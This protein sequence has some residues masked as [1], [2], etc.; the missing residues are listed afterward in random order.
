MSH[1]LNTIK[2]GL[3]QKRVRNLLIGLYVLV[4]IGL[5][6][7]ARAEDMRIFPQPPKAT[8]STQNLQVFE[9][10]IVAAVDGRTFLVTEASTYELRGS[11]DLTDLNGE[12][13]RVVGT[14]I[15]HKVGPVYQYMSF[16]PLQNDDAQ[17]AAAPVVIVYNVSVL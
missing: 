3:L 15:K 2:N 1:I 17:Y 13:V 8:Q 5:S 6:A 10:E 7:T 4:I 11:Q 12:F 14:E 9:G 16:N